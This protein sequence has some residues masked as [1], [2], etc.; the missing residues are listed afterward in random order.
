MCGI[1]EICTC[2][3]FHFTD[4]G[5]GMKEICTCVVLQFST[6]L[7]LDVKWRKSVFVLCCNF[8]LHWLWMSKLMK[9]ICT[10]VLYCFTDSGCR[11]KEI[12]VLLQS[13]L[14]W[15][16]GG[17]LQVMGSLLLFFYFQITQPNISTS[18]GCVYLLYLDLYSKFDLRV[19]S[20]SMYLAADSR[21]R[22]MKN[23]IFL[24]YME[25]MNVFNLSAA[26]HALVL[27][28]SYSRNSCTQEHK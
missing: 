6:L 21:P 12:C 19:V 18:K 15:W 7:T 13:W 27:K 8:L 14:Q 10:C 25:S 26:T 9:E 23:Y 2:V 17:N 20:Q 22:K 5:C 3:V 24:W 16:N 28:D 11:M 1:K 4:S